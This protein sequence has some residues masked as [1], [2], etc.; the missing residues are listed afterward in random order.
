MRF[1]TRT[2][3]RS[4]SRGDFSHAQ[5]ASPLDFIVAGLGNPGSDYDKTRHNAGFMALDALAK[6]CGSDVTQK[7]FQA[8]TARVTLDGARLLL[9]KPQTFMNLSGNA[10]GAAASFFKV[11]PER[12]IVLC[13]DISLPLGKIRVRGDGSAGGH[14][15]LKSIIAQ[16]GSESF[17]RVKIGIGGAENHDDKLVNWVIGRFSAGEYKVVQAAA[18]GASDAV[19][20]IIRDGVEKAANLFNGKSFS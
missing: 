2:D 10:V 7:R 16:L 11:P 20:I 9:M 14:N 19:R 4:K 3:N 6:F 15:G 8:L 17:P 18:E 13:D 5:S 12:I 1:F